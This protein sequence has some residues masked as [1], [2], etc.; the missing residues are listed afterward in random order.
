[1]NLAFYVSGRAKRLNFLIEANKNDILSNVRVVFSDDNKNCYLKEKLNKYK[2]DYIIIDYKKISEKDKNLY[3]SNVMLN[4]FKN[5][6]IDYCFSFG[7][8][9][10]KGE[11]LKKYEKRIINF[12]PSI[13]PLF[14]GIKAIDK[15]IDSNVFLL[16]NTAHF[17]DDGIDTGP[18]IMQSIIPAY[19]FKKGEYDSVLNIQLEM[20]YQ[21]YFLLEKNKIKIIKNKV[22]IDNANYDK[23]IIFPFIE[24]SKN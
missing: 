18:I 21:I 13:L 12:H 16:G 23:Y 10:L 4:V 3:I 14:P 20:L 22:I 8:H 24:N 9:L 7:A 15:A 2:I 19:S 11:L 5:Y 6:K 17:I 1:M